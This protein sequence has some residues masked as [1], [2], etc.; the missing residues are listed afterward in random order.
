MN[1]TKTMLSI[2]LVCI[3]AGA[4]YLYWSR[5]PQ[6]S[7]MKLGEAVQHHDG[8][9]FRK[10]CDV[11]SVAASAVSDLTSAGVS[12]VGGP[13][14]LQRLLG[15]ALTGFLKPQISDLLAKNIIDY[16][17]RTPE[18]GSGSSGDSGNASTA[19]KENA[20]SPEGSKTG[21][22]L[23]RAVEGFVRDVVSAIKPPSLREVLKDLGLTRQNYKGLTDFEIKGQICHVGMI[24]Q[25][26]GQKNITVMLELENVE[27][28][29]RL[30]RISNLGVLA[31]ILSASAPP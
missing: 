12:E 24:F 14:L 29:W 10:Y 5:T 7:I 20:P 25:P 6:Y 11:D 17:E 23:E 4:G 3:L 26:P 22:K 2:L 31:G 18:Q 15:I 30:I 16:V 13:R 21:E 28:R 1:F 9:S 27:N 19:G 8:D